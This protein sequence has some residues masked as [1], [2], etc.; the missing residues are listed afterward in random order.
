MTRKNFKVTNNKEAIEQDET[1][2]LIPIERLEMPETIRIGYSDFKIIHAND[3]DHFV[4]RDGLMGMCDNAEQVIYMLPDMP[5]QNEAATLLHEVIHALFFYFG[6]GQE[7]RPWTQEDYV[8]ASA[9]GLAQVFQNNPEFVAYLM[10]NL[11]V[12]GFEAYESVEA[13]KVIN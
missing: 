8:G 4:K 13:K 11:K 2:E 1:Q 9:N 12:P 5:M 6:D 3:K 7:G 10:H